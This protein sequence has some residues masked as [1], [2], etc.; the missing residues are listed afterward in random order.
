[1]SFRLRVL[2][3]ALFIAVTATTAT[4][5]LTL[6]QAS[7][8]LTETITADRRETA[9]IT[10]RLA[11][12]GREY[13]TWA[14]LD[15]TVRALAS[16]TGE[17]I[18][19]VD[20]AGSLLTDSDLLAGRP[21]RPVTGPAL[22]IDPRPTIQ[23]APTTGPP[24]L[25]AVQYTWAQVTYYHLGL[26]YAACLTEAGVPARST[27]TASGVPDY[28][29]V[30]ARPRDL[31]AADRCQ[32]RSH[33]ESQSLL[34]ASKA[35]LRGSLAGL[36]PRF[37]AA[38]QRCGQPSATRLAT[39]LQA[40]FTVQIGEYAPDRV[41]VY[42]GAGTDRPAT[43]RW[44]SSALGVLGVGTV[45]MLAAWLLSRRVLR[46]IGA[47]TAASRRLGA[48]DRGERVEV[49]GRDELADLGRE[50]NRMAAALQ[51]SEERQRRMVADVAHELR[52][53]LANLRG[54]LEAL[55][56]GVLPPTP[57]LFASLHEEALLQQ[58]IVDDLQDLALAEAGTLAYHRGQV[59]LA[60]LAEACRTAH[61]P[62]TRAAGLVVAVEAA[63]PVRID[64]DADRLRQVVGNLVRNAVAATPAGG[65]I[66][67]RVRAG[68]GRAT[69]E[70]ADT[71]A[72]IAAAD[73]PY[74]FD[75]FWRGDRSR[76]RPS[77]G[78][79]GLAIAQRIVTDHGGSISV[80][81]Q[82]GRGTTFTIA[83]PLT[84]PPAGA[85]AASQ[86]D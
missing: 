20:E 78:G 52:T 42:L 61:D 1:M 34:T 12:Y 81:S 76:G 54:Y 75:R 80:T 6:R 70:V 62:Q 37:R 36:P 73:L 57:E 7:R 29:A 68:E 11:A 56:D 65:T 77:G 48:G 46:P 43:L 10:D 24:L 5:W 33:A 9:L 60:E 31:T 26:R 27:P 38:A 18:R 55:S 45:A 19:V 4:A 21:A 67:L 64:G 22:L 49:A 41:Q 25:T 32:A 71:G 74:V 30:L 15:G 47:L 53:P 79:L 59:D 72:G 35:L 83:L 40:A 8:Q 14:R 85:P 16:Q 82:P 44:R 51:D 69:I 50:F 86:P 23:L 66:T 39:C 13:G 63:G 28:S 2:A 17:R 84:A 58:R 3:L